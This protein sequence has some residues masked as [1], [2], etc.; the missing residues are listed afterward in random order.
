MRQRGVV[1]RDHPG[2]ELQFPPAQRGR[3]RPVR[4]GPG[5]LDRFAGGRSAQAERLRTGD[6]V[7]VEHQTLAAGDRKRH[8]HLCGRRGD[9]TVAAG[10]TD[11]AGRKAGIGGR[12]AARPERGPEKPG[13]R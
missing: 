13:P 1:E 3:V 6:R 4:P 5:Q 10:R 2:A 8:A 7:E 9:F 11:V 12:W